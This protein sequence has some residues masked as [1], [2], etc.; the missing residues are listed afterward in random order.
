MATVSST[1]DTAEVEENGGVDN[2][3]N[4]E[5]LLK[6]LEKQNRLVCWSSNSVCALLHCIVMTTCIH[7]TVVAVQTI[8]DMKS[9]VYLNSILS[10]TLSLSFI[11]LYV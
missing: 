1:S 10:L 9:L 5:C 11:F 8:T 7:V 2:Q 6:M 4:E 3:D